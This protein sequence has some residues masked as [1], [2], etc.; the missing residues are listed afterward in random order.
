MAYFGF[1]TRLVALPEPAP[2]IVVRAAADACRDYHR[3]H[4]R[5]CQFLY[6]SHL[7]LYVLVWRITLIAACLAWP[8]TL[9]LLAE[10]PVSW[11]TY[12]LL[13]GAIM[14]AAVHLLM[15]VGKAATALHRR[16]LALEMS[17]RVANAYREFTRPGS[18]AKPQNT[19][20][21]L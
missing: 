12:L 6:A 21:P 14:T 4:C 3:D 16:R 18:P 11:T 17:I 7:V 1:R 20:S 15:L 19:T 5:P 8:M 2:E 10:N 9:L 13:G